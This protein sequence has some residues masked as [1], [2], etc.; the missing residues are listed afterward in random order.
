[1]WAQVGE[2]VEKIRKGL[3]LSKAQFGKMIGV[4]GQYIGMIERGSG[5]SVDSIVK[6]C[7]TA[8][9]SADYILFGMID[10]A[11]D[12]VTTAS[13][14]G[15]SHEQIQIALDIIKKVAQFVN[16]ED[17]NEALIREVASQ[18]HMCKASNEMPK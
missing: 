4:S 12:L 18:Q 1:M 7:Y 2:R 17:G 15:L 8:G 14:C 11:Q 16:T 9:V 3:N 5:L 10:P 13:L 6:I